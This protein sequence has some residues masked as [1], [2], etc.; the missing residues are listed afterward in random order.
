MTEIHCFFDTLL[1]IILVVC[2]T[3]QRSNYHDFYIVINFPN[4]DFALIKMANII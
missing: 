4:I 2:T 1:L 3:I